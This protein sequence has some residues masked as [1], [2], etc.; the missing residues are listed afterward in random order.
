MLVVLDISG[1][2]VFGIVI[3]IVLMIALI[4]FFVHMA[5]RN[6]VKDQEKPDEEKALKEEMDRVL[7]PVDDEE[8]ARHIAEYKDKEDGLLYISYST[9]VS[10]G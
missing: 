7:K 2:A 4:A 5:L 9:E 3:G 6:K 10:W 1:G 8:T